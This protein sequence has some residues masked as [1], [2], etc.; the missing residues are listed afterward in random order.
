MNGDDHD[1][2]LKSLGF[3]ILRLFGNVDEKHISCAC[4]TL[5]EK[6]TG[7]SRKMENN[8]DVLLRGVVGSYFFLDKN[9]NENRR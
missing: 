7:D 6:K 5:L 4:I 3:Q 9:N 8:K 2:Y 1:K